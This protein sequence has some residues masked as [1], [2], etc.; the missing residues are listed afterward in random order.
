GVETVYFAD[1]KIKS[2][3]TLLDGRKSGRFTEYFD[4]KK[5]KIKGNH[6]YDLREGKW[7]YYDQQ[8]KVTKYESYSRGKLISSSEN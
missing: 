4:G 1:K 8:G 6:R 3:I 2:E 7:E 5:V